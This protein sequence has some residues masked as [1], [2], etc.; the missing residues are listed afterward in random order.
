MTLNPKVWGPHG[1]FFMHSITLAYPDSPTKEDKENIIN[2]FN[3]V[4]KV[5]PCHKCRKN[6]KK[7]SAKLPLTD[8]IVSSREE[9]VKWLIDFHNEVNEVTHKPKLSY[10]EVMD[11]YANAYKEPFYT[12]R[13][14]N[15][16]LIS[17]LV[18][19]L[20]ILIYVFMRV[21]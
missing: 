8:K 6:F 21:V 16:V 7:H 14:F 2:F 19:I 17:T 1:W 10:E 20:L 18:A 3:S 13:T 15:I 5:L 12:S 4:G 9:L 11:I